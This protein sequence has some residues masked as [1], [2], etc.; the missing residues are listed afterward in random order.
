MTTPV[1]A[2]FDDTCHIRGDVYEGGMVTTLPMGSIFENS[3][4]QFEKS[5][6]VHESDVGTY[7][8]V[9]VKLDNY[10]DIRDNVYGGDMNM[11]PTVEY[12]FENSYA[13]FENY[14]SVIEGDVNVSSPLVHRSDYPYDTRENMYG[15]DMNKTHSVEVI[16]ENSCA[17]FEND[18]NVRGG[19]VDTSVSIELISLDSSHIIDKIYKG[20]MDMTL[21]AENTFE[22]FH[23]PLLQ[24]KSLQEGDINMDLITFDDSFDVRGNIYGGDMDLTVTVGGILSEFSHLKNC[25]IYIRETN[26]ASPA[27][28]TCA[29]SLDERENIYGGDMN[30]TFPIRTILV[31]P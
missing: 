15:G 7:V 22:N 26:M 14:L 19:N 9:E 31:H 25:R 12:T 3:S 27:K 16:F 24:D 13:R 23:C 20:N 1:G 18:L 28:V 6:S 29:D 17:Q 10:S 30:I 2:I 4:N 11:T 21:R 8:P 5:Q